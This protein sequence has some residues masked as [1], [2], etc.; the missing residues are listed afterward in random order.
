MRVHPSIAALRRDGTQQRLAQ[1]AMGVTRE[2]W[3]EQAGVA[4][5]LAEFQAY[6][7]GETLSSCPALGALFAGGAA[8]RL[9][10]A[11]FCATFA[12]A[13]SVEPLGHLSFRHGFDGTRATLLLGRCG[14]ARL[15][16]VAHEP[17][18][19]HAASVVFSDAVRHDAIVAGKAAAQVVRRRADGFLLHEHVG[20]VPGRCLA[21]D[22]SHE[23]LCLRRIERRLVSLRLHRTSDA[24]GPTREHSLADGRLLHQA[25]GDIR[26][27]RLEMMLAVLGRMKRHEAAPL[28]AELACRDGPDPL[29]WEA[30]REALALDTARG[31]AALCR[32]SRSPDD[33]LAA[34][35]AGLRARLVETHP[36]LLAL[37]EA[38]C[39]A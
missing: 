10:V 31:F 20:L 28:M 13:L 6:A 19:R 29:R 18:E 21:L 16:L 14:N 38:P 23:A 37:E 34:P 22:S 35:A 4:P 12:S 36:R 8:A 25:A 3:Q 24:P 2:R 11:R 33:P 39:P 32:I 30:L 7:R 5:V 1:R 17:G 27:S 26:Q 9:F 15:A